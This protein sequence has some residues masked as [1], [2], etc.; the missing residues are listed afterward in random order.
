MPSVLINQSPS[1]W[2][3]GDYVIHNLVRIETVYV[4]SIAITDGGSAVLEQ[5]EASA[6]GIIEC[7]SRQVSQ[8]GYHT[9]L[10]ALWEKDRKLW[11]T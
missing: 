7:H 9:Q 8:R 3:C 10:E 2:G 1:K 4:A 5:F 6:E 11:T